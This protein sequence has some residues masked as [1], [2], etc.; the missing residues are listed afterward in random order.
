MLG[1]SLKVLDQSCLV[2]FEICLSNTVELRGCLPPFS[3]SHNF[4]VSPSMLCSSPKWPLLGPH[5]LR[6]DMEG[7]LGCCLDAVGVGQRACPD[8]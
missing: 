2:W 3:H 6:Q 4:L 5:G 1:L 8:Y 7:E